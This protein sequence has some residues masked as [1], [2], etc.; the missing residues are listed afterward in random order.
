MQRALHSVFSLSALVLTLAV[1]VPRNARAAAGAPATLAFSLPSAPARPRWWAAV[2]EG[3]RLWE[4]GERPAAVEKWEEAVEQGFREGIAF[5]HLGM[6]YRDQEDY[7]RAADYLR[8]SIPFLQSDGASPEILAEAHASLAATFLKLREYGE[9]YINY[10]K[11]L[12]RRPDF[13]AAQLGMGTL[14]L[15]MGRYAA[16]EAAAAKVLATEPANARAL[17]IVARAAEMAGDFHRAAERYRKVLEADPSWWE[18]RQTL[19]TILY[20]RLGRSDEAR[21]ELE[22]VLRS[23]PHAASAR[24]LLSEILYREGE[25]ARAR[26]EAL[27]ALR[28]DPDSP[29]ALVV[30]GQILLAEGKRGEAEELFRRALR[31][32]GGAPLAHYG[33]GMIAGEE[34]KWAE[35]VEHFRAALADYPAFAEARYNLAAALEAEGQ[36][37]EALSTLEAAVAAN[38][39]FFPAQ[40]GRGRLLYLSG[41]YDRAIAALRNAQALDPRSWEAAYF[42]GKCYVGKKDDR[43]GIAFLAAAA[44]LAPEN[45]AVLSDLGLA[46]DRAGKPE[47]ARALFR[48]ALAA[49]PGYARASLLLAVLE[50]RERR[51]GGAWRQA[52]I[53]KPGESSWGFDGEEEDFAEEIVAGLDDYLTAGIDY[54]SLYELIRNAYRDRP[55]LKDFVPLLEKKAAQQPRKPQF[56]H[57]LGLAFQDAGRT[58]A[59]EASFQKALRIDPDFAAAHLNLGYLYAN[60]GKAAEAK[61]HFEA[62]LTLSPDSEL[63]VAVRTFLETLGPGE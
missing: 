28:D 11:A 50:G 51:G 42:L 17:W 49:D 33:L 12:K 40:V 55:I 4:A 3:N 61:K 20:A 22:A 46:Y 44:E 14:Y 37:E 53:V 32:P 7:E 36:R 5:Y 6:Y 8:Q 9:A 35:A 34:K 23:S 59:A 10:Q 41:L 57:L 56:Q 47:E 1:P 19:A 13:P 52:L 39:G 24:A 62:F 54:L 43:N 2:E 21:R 27:S 25:T 38:P 18:T 58:A 45:P 16:A 26:A 48:R 31:A 15:A 30:L 63:A 29:Q 60:Q